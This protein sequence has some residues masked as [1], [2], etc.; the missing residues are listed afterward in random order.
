MDSDLSLFDHI[1]GQHSVSDVSEVKTKIKPT[2]RL[3]INPTK[4]ALASESRK[5]RKVTRS[6][7]TQSRKKMT[8]KA[9]SATALLNA[10]TQPS[11]IDTVNMEE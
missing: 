11:A 7:N 9:Q 6:A 5:S 4:E 8:R 2:I 3:G 10:F 1:D